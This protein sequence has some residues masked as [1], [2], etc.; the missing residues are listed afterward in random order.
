MAQQRDRA[1]T[2]SAFFCVCLGWGRRFTPISWRKS[3][4]RLKALV[5]LGGTGDT[6]GAR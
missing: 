3:V 5:Q 6:L 2:V 1:L 4:N